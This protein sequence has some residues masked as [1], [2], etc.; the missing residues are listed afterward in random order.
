MKPM[1]SNTKPTHEKRFA[2]TPHFPYEL[3]MLAVSF[4]AYINILLIFLLPK[5][6]AL[7]VV[8]VVDQFIAVLFLIDFIRRFVAA[9]SKTIYFFKEYGWADLLAAVPISIFNAFRVIRMF[10][11]MRFA[12]QEGFKK[13]LLDIRLQLAN[14]MLYVVFFLILLLLEF[15]S[16]S[17]LFVE[18]GAPGAVIK[19]ASDALWWVF[20]SITTVGYGDMYPV[21]NGGRLIGAGT[22]AIGVILYAVLTGYIVDTI[23][24]KRKIE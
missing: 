14:A 9:K 4:L 3:F 12:R 10:R 21:T 23:I 7:D 19:T 17:I 13:V 8:V 5:G 18:G 24:S 1:S 6:H 11:F 15:G 20:V 2:N 16:M 22:L